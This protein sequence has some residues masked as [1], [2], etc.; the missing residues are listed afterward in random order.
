MMSPAFFLRFLFLN[1]IAANGGM[2]KSATIS[3]ATK[4]I[5]LVNANG[6][7]SFPSAPVIVKTGIKLMIVVKTAVKI[8][9]ETSEV[10]W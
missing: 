7:K 6:R 9:P 2:R 5:V 3:E 10:A 4:A 1:N 8:A